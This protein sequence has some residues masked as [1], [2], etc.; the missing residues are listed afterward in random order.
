MNLT[1]IIFFQFNKK[2]KGDFESGS[3][4]NNYIQNRIKNV[5][6]IF[7]IKSCNRPLDEENILYGWTWRTTLLEARTQRVK[8]I[9]ITA[10]VVY[11]I[12]FIQYMH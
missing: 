3:D 2:I 9:R 11:I 1:N 6:L 8:I 10:T 12:R 4:Q 5:E 7:S